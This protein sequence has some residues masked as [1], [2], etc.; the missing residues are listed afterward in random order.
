MEHPKPKTFR[1]ETYKAWIRTNS[2]HRCHTE[3]DI[4]AA[5]QTLSSD[6]KGTSLKVSDA[7]TIPLCPTCHG[8]EHHNHDRF[9][10]MDNVALIVI[11]Y[12]EK[13]IN[14]KKEK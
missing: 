5:H 8:V 7:Q 2:C 3:I 6:Q 14:Q 13:Y 1:S 10:G 11:S 9:W 4:Q 12:L